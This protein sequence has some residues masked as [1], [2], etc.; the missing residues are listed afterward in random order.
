MNGREPIVARNFLFQFAINKST[1][2]LV[3]YLA[4]RDCCSLAK[5]A[6]DGKKKEKKRDKSLQVGRIKGIK[7]R[8]VTRISLDPRPPS[9]PE[10]NGPDSKGENGRRAQGE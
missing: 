3:N 9:W 10:K 4:A 1:G 6:R 5:V 2:P 8:L 7:G